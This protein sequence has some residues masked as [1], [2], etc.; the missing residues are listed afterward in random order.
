MDK[1]WYRNPSKSEVTGRCCGDEKNEWP[2][3][4]NKS[5]TLKTQQKH[6]YKY[7][8]VSFVREQKMMLRVLES[9][10][11]FSDQFISKWGLFKK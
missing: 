10:I 6:N 9:T 4:T 7:D 3:I 11:K 1:I 8:S 5:R 2:R